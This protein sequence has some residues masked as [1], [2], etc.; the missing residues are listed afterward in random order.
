MKIDLIK[1]SA[2][3]GKTYT[4]MGLL[5]K[6]IA[7]GV[8][9]EGLL[10]TTFTV[11]AAAELQSRIR[12]E[13]LSGTQPE[14]A[15]QVFD[16]LIG[17]V[18]GVCGQLLS[19][20]AIES[21]LSPALDVL[22]EENADMIFSAAANTVMEEFA[23]E[24]E[25]VAARLELNALKE[26][27]FGKTL[28]WRKD[29]RSIVD[30]ARS[31]RIDEDKLIYCAE[32]SCTA[33]KEIFTAEKDLSL[34][35]IA[36]MVSP[37][38]QFDAHGVDTIKAVR[39]IKDFLRFPT[40]GGAVRLG[41]C[42]YT[43]TKDPEFPI[44]ILQSINSM[45]LS[46]RELYSDI[47]TVIRGVF[48]CAGKALY[49]YDEYK[50]AFG[51][52]DFV[53]QESNVLALL[54]NNENFRN[55][56]KQRINQIMVDEF[57]D[58]SPI[59]LALFLKLHECSQNGSVWV[60]DPKQAIYGFRGTD[61]ELMAAVA[62]T[63]PDY[64]TLEYSWRS[65]ENLVELSNAIFKRAFDKMPQKDVV[66]GIHT[67]RKAAAAGGGIA[68]WHLS[69]NSGKRMAALAGGIAELI[70]KENVVP[71]DICVLFRSNDECAALAD[72]LAQWNIA[73]SAPAGELMEHT[74]CQLV[75]AAYR[76]CIDNSDTAALAALTALY[77]EDPQWLNK[78]C[79]ARALELAMLQG[80]QK[81][82]DTFG[83][84]KAEPW[85]QKLVKPADA[86]PLEILEYVIAA[87][88]LDRKISAM[89]NS[90]LRMSNL[91]ELYKVCNQYMNQ[92]LVNRTA[93]TP[94]GFVAMLNNSTAASAAGFGRNTVN[95]MTYHKSKGLEF[96]VVILGSL[97]SAGKNGAFGIHAQQ[98][99]SFDANAPL[100]G[101]TIHYW[102]WPFGGLKKFDML[103]SALANN[104]I[105]QY[106][107]TR[108]CEESKRLF[109]VGL[110]R[111]KDQLIFAIERKSPT[112]TELKSNPD[113]VDTLKINWLDSLS[114][115]PIFDFPMTVDQG[116]LTVGDETFEITTRLLEE[117]Q[118][119]EP[120]P[121]PL[122]Y[123]ESCA[124]AGHIAPARKS[125]SSESAEG[126]AVLLTQWDYFT[127]NI[128]C[129]KGKFNLLGS[130]FHDFIAMNPRTNGRFYAE[131][132]LKNYGVEQ[133]VAPEVL[134][135][136]CQNLY[137]YLEEA[138]PA[139]EVSCEVPLTYHDENGTLYQ[140][141]IDMLL[142][143]PEGFVIIDH[144]TH[145]SEHDAQEYAAG[146]AGQLEL[147]RKAVEA[148]TGKKVLQTIIHLPNLGKCYEVKGK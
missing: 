79:K 118:E 31:N 103:S 115:N 10:A 47:C 136:C 105:Q 144:K 12:Q 53:D 85:L 36:A 64:R 49:A 57:Q 132:L 116:T 22:P 81:P 127:G 147:Y 108:D 32:K 73:A 59:Q 51:L 138:Y 15:V 142:D 80:D 128:K 29:V 16:G 48:A 91:N 62:A 148:A 146:C 20:Y 13:L 24:L 119:V 76:Y 5:S 46:S 131:R 42:Q 43:K 70:T 94:A 26:N 88:E 38:R 111:A 102:P 2:G 27:P 97:D 101:R 99:E 67:D 56:M 139:A 84:I 96:P 145:P 78:F 141:F 109:Y 21:G 18:N 23:D 134:V 17:T 61:P 125:P 50:K 68:A 83:S 107:E 92:A 34:D 66:L 98:A 45:I 40:W 7:S 39:T 110:T 100:Q 89:P 121:S 87:L 63:V 6:S 129:E 9:P 55:L 35:D 33:L 133:A 60:G 71:G 4:L 11:K 143:L 106:V 135:E 122:V 30:L 126:R 90:D 77:G 58:T 114:C 137:N 117:P 113:A 28:D 140:G 120:L 72:A 93:A 124:T 41:N 123:T 44:D 130:A 95:I 54:E 19:E 69:G 82:G 8:K 37:Y 112:K 52:I 65:R 104:P 1:A 75:M 3:S 74:E 25:K 14:L 86:T